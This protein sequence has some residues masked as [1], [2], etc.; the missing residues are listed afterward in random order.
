MIYNFAAGKS[1]AATNA[2]SSVSRFSSAG[3]I[4]EAYLD[5]ETWNVPDLI[6]FN[7]A[8]LRAATRN[9]AYCS[10]GQGGLE[11]YTKD[12]FLRNRN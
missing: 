3:G 11:E 6:V 1:Q 7:F 8:Q 10:L 4:E 5:G 12:T 9:F 2:T